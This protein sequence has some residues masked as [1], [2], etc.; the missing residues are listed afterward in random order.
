MVDPTAWQIFYQNFTNILV[1]VVGFFLVRTLRQV[2]RRLESMDEK[3]DNHETRIS[4][5]EGQGYRRYQ[6]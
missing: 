3:V 2:E 4:R 1:A 5:V 6:R